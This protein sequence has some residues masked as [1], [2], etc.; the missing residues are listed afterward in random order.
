MVT[1]RTDERI[2]VVNDPVEHGVDRSDTTTGGQESDFV[3][4][5]AERSE[6]TGI[7]TAS[8]REVADTVVV[9]TAVDS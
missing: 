7:T 2:D 4:S 5:E 3:T 1:G 6:S 8:R 9:V